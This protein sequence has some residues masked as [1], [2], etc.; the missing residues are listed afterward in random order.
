MRPSLRA[1]GRRGLGIVLSF[2]FLTIVSFGVGSIAPGDA[3]LSLLRTD[4][5]AV[6][7]DDVASIRHELGL[8]RPWPERYLRFLGG[9]AR[10]SL[11]DSYFSGHTVMGDIAKA[12]PITINLSL[13]SLVLAV[14][15]VLVL[16]WLA[17][18]YQGSILDKLILGLCYV[19]AALPSFWLGLLL[20]SLFAVSLGWLPSSGWHGG[21][22]L[23]LPTVV[24]AVAIAPPFIK[25]FR[26]RFIEVADS[27]FVRAARARGLKTST[28]E[29]RHVLRGTLV[30]IVTMLGV[31]LTSLLSGSVVVEVVFGLPGLGS[32]V[33]EAIGRR[34][35][36]VVQGFVFVI[37]VVVIAVMQ[38]VD[39]ACR[40]IDPSLKAG[41][42]A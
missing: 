36:P 30:P 2:L 9:L 13:A 25:V 10:G 6:N 18:K 15:F 23:I 8:D 35:W 26:G 33:M 41:E 12:A 14:A 19:G 22:G 34:D 31:S 7:T 42:R 28:I 40:L 3:S 24:L 4:T 37:G 11:G 39:V 1:W 38:L 32:M 21:R 5:V 20:I 16:G 29:R 27:D 17:A